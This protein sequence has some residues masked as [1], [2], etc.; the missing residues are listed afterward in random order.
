MAEGGGSWCGALMRRIQ[1]F[2]CSTTSLPSVLF[3][4]K[5]AFFFLFMWWMMATTDLVE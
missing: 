1:R 3:A 2:S 5:E 4:G